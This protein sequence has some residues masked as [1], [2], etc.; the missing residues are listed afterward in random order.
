MALIDKYF[1]FDENMTE[2]EQAKNGTAE[3]WI[4]RGYMSS[5]NDPYSVYYTA[6]EL[7]TLVGKEYWPF[8]TY[9]D[10]LFNV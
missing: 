10:L 7:E 1:L 5:L 9:D 6:D 3:D 8:P 4:Y 2:E